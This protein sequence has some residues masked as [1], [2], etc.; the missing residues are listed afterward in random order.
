MIYFTEPFFSVRFNPSLPDSIRNHP[1][2]PCLP[3]DSENTNCVG[4]EFGIDAGDGLWYNPIRRVHGTH[5]TGTIGANGLNNV[6]IQG[7]VNDGN[8]CFII[9]RVFGESSEGTRISS[10][11]DAIEWVADQGADVINLSLGVNE[12]HT[13]GETLMQAIYEEGALI[14]AASGNS[15]TTTLHYPASYKDVLSV[16]AVDAKRHHASF[17]QHN[18]DVDIVAPGVDILS[19]QP[20]NVSSAIFLSTAEFGASGLYFEHSVRFSASISG[21]LVLCPNYGSELC[22]GSGGHICLIER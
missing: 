19:T 1:D 7:I 12:Y 2:I 20:L 9:G 16:G 21:P 6:G 15:G 13:S 18:S 5:V 17:S 8:L 10:I 3:L 22:P 4:K 11:F 14:V